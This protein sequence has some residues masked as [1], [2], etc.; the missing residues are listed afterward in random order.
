[1]PHASFSVS[2]QSNM[3]SP[4][5]R[6]KGTANRL[7][8]ANMLIMVSDNPKE[9]NTL[10]IKVLKIQR[11]TVTAKMPNTIG[12]CGIAHTKAC[13]GCAKPLC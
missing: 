12:S 13:C 7:I 3:K 2:F 9:G 6:L 8:A 4:F 1:M 11:D 10:L 5:F